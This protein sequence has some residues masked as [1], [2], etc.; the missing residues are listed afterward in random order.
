MQ[1]NKEEVETHLDIISKYIDFIESLYN[2]Y[3]Y[4]KLNIRNKLVLKD[5]IYYSDGLLER[6][7]NVFDYIHCH[8]KNTYNL[9]LMDYI[10]LK[11]SGKVKLDTICRESLNSIIYINKIKLLLETVLRFINDEFTFED[12][13]YLNCNL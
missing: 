3:I 1:Y 7:T 9:F 6:L 5:L 13:M 2:K 4:V 8:F 11:Q 12:E 10:C